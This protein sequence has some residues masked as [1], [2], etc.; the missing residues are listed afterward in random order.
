MIPL[1]TGPG[2]PIR[3]VHG[4]DLLCSGLLVE[5]MEVQSIF[6]MP[7]ARVGI[8]QSKSSN[9]NFL[10]NQPNSSSEEVANDTPTYAEIVTTS[11]HL[12]NTT[13]GLSIE[14]AHTSIP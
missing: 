10:S 8:C 4:R 2:S 1:R 5:F 13:S 9:L 12:Q 7:D 6:Q 14:L 11:Y 3:A